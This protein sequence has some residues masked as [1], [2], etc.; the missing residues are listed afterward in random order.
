MSRLVTHRQLRAEGFDAHEVSRKVS[1]GS[2]HR[3]RRGVYLDGE[4]K[5]DRVGRYLVQC[6]AV[7]ARCGP[8]TVLSHASAAAAW[9]LPLPWAALGTVHVIQPRR[10]G[11]R[12][13]AG[14]CVHQAKLGDDACLRFGH[15]VTTLP[16]TLVDLGRSLDLGWAVAAMDDALHHQ[17]CAHHELAT[18]LR[19]QAG[20]PGCRG[21]ARAVALADHKSES[22][23][24]SLSRVLL[25]QAGLG[26]DEL[27][28]EFPHS[29]GVDRVDFWWECGVV[30][31]FD[32][33]LKYR[34]QAMPGMSPDEVLWA[35]KQREDR[36][37]RRGLVVVRWTWDELLHQPEVVVARIREALATARAAP[38]PS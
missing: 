6:C 21:A 31:E 37:R 16:R 32:G 22:V 4:P 10:K 33:Q 38:R 3:I 13:R 19:D 7:L 35:E 18:A 25:V 11:G 9:G 1:A 24:E 20:R 28:H 36:L 12:S 26:P 23:G 5:D 17:R 27:Q 30:G 15:R 8:E 34:A 14:V 29:D 2:F